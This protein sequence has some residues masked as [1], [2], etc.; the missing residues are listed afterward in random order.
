[1]VHCFKHDQVSP[2]PRCLLLSPY[3]PTVA[4]LK[5]IVARFKGVLMPSLGRRWDIIVSSVETI[6]GGE[7][8]V[9][10]L[11]TAVTK[12]TH[13]EKPSL[14]FVDT[15]GSLLELA[16]ARWNVALLYLIAQC[17]C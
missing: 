6:M 7:G 4:E 14:M 17:S 16:K 3:L 8:D 15:P 5:D 12:A 1:M 13:P 2:N 10:I 9:S 11:V